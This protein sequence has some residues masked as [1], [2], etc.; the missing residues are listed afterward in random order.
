MPLDDIAGGDAPRGRSRARDRRGRRRQR[1]R[2]RAQR[3]RRPGKVVAVVSGGNIDLLEVRR[4]RSG[5]TC[6]PTVRPNERYSP[7]AAPLARPHPSPARTRAR[8]VV[9]LGLP[10]APGLPPPRLHA[11]AGHGAQPGA[12]AADASRAERL[13]RRGRRPGV[14]AGRTTRRSSGSTRRAAVAHPWWQERAA[15]INGG[16]HRLLL[17]GVRAA[18]V[19]AD[20]C[21]RPR[22]A[23]RRS[24]QGGQRPRRAARRRRLHVSAGLLPPADVHRR[25]AGGALRAHQLDRGA[26]RSGAHARRQALHHRG[27]ARRSHR[28]GRGL[29]RA[30]RPRAPV[31][32]RHRPAGERAVGSRAVGAPLRRRSRD[33]HPAGDRPRHRRRR[34]RCARWA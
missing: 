16:S 5:R 1:R 9:E 15:M 34:A 21:G 19:A 25:L 12:D 26:D 31:P 23:G 28:A 14:P 22:R 20:L 6:T 7:T 10:R 30:P 33:A 29:A 2:R 32:A 27:A 17:G 18:P 11:V 4:S 8:P 3:P 24:L 13:A